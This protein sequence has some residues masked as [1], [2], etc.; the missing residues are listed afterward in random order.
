MGNDKSRFAERAEQIEDL[1]CVHANFL[2]GEGFQDMDYA[3]DCPADKL[4]LA[5]TANED[6]SL[7]YPINPNTLKAPNDS[8]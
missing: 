3:E 6:P 2:G 8:Q 1:N 5:H 7:L 4:V